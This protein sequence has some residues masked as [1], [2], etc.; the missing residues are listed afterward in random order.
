VSA[1]RYS[2]FLTSRGTPTRI[3]SL[4]VRRAPW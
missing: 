3:V 4:L 1:T 2:R